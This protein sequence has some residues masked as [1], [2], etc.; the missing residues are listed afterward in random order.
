MSMRYDMFELNSGVVVEP[1]PPDQVTD[2]DDLEPSFGF[3]FD[4]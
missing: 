1:P 4:I 3:D 2:V